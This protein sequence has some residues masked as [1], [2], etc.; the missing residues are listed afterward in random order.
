[1]NW[2]YTLRTEEMIEHL[3]KWILVTSEQIVNSIVVQLLSGVRLFLTTSTE[4][5]QAYLS[6]PISWS[7]LKLMSIESM[8]PSN[9]LF[10]CSPFFFLSSIFPSIR[11]FSNQLVLCIGWPK[12]RSFS[13]SV[14]LSNEYSGLISF[15]TDWFDLNPVTSV[16]RSLN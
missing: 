15:R 13:F 11:V 9:H 16:L 10:L 6:F 2:S 3:S 8:I 5:H 7:F 12:Y 14:N 4:G 1:M